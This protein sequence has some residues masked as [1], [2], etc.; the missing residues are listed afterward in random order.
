MQQALP[1]LPESIREQPQ[2]ASQPQPVSSPASG[3]GNT[4]PGSVPV[5]GPVVGPGSGL[6][7][8][9]RSPQ[10]VDDP[11]EEDSLDDDDD[12]LYDW[13]ADED[14]LLDWD[15]DED[16]FQMKINEAKNAAGSM[17]HDGMRRGTDLLSPALENAR[18]YL[19]PAR[20]IR[21]PM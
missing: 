2:P 18:G 3:S 1:L 21:K 19:K 5:A 6:D 14:N 12:D 7:S 9:S 13:E 16:T 10:P 20:R 8:N 15:D 4:A 17:F 11:W